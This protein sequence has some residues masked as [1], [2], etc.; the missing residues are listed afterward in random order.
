MVSVCGCW[1]VMEVGVMVVGEALILTASSLYVASEAMT[2]AA[3]VV[4]GGV[5]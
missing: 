2:V 4:Y 3:G 1:V 5:G